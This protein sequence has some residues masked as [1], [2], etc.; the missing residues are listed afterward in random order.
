MRKLLTAAM[1]LLLSIGAWAQHE[2]Y[3][4]AL[5][6]YNEG[7]LDLAMQYLQKQCSEA[8]CDF[9]SQWLGMEIFYSAQEYQL[10]GQMAQ[11]LLPELK[12]DAHESRCTVYAYMA[13]AAFEN[14]DYKTANKLLTN[15][16]KEDPKSS[17]CYYER[18]YT[19]VAQEHYD[20][21]IK[22]LKKSIEFEPDR[23]EAYTLAGL[24]YEAKK[25]TVNMHKCYQTA[26]EKTNGETPWVWC[27]YGATYLNRGQIDRAI[28]LLFTAISLDPENARTGRFYNRLLERNAV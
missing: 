9:A 20:A 17:Y 14:E 19:S 11:K 21:A 7:N 5:A 3:D 8:E 18:A 2:Y 25:D 28:D 6:A 1:M 12:K 15:A 4:K 10:A 16:L 24:C 23:I 27:E 22:D 13:I 26:L